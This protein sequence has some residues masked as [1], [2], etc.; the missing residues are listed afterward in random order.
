MGTQNILAKLFFTNAVQF[1]ENL[2]DVALQ[3]TK[4]WS[5]KHS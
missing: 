4:N 1:A 5:I 2:L 3:I